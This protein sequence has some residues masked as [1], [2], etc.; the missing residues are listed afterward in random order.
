[1]KGY[2][3]LVRVKEP[4]VIAGGSRLSTG[5]IFEVSEHEFRP[6]DPFEPV[7]FVGYEPAVL[8]G[9]EHREHRQPIY[10]RVDPNKPV[11]SEPSAS[12][13]LQPR[14]SNALGKWWRRIVGFG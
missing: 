5:A 7:R 9:P 3:G 13:A 10:E 1:M 2:T 12:T 14:D 6:D 11:P 8:I 4:C